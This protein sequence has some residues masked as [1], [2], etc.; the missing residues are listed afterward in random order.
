VIPS[1]L[2]IALFFISIIVFVY[3]LFFADRAEGAGTQALLMGSV[4]AVITVMLLLLGFLDNPF[5]TG[6]GTLEPTAMERT[7]RIA[8]EALGAI[9]DT[10]RPPCDAQGL[11]R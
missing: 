11:P 10:V 8:D 4:A 5:G 9:G 2:W 6:V 1:P 7:L 3:L